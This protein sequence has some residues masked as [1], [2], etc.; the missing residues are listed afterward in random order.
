MKFLAQL[1]RAVAE[2][3]SAAIVTV[4]RAEGSTPR[5]QGAWMIVRPSGGFHGT[6]GGGALEWSLLHEAIARLSAGERGAQDFSRV[7]GPDLGQCCGGRVRGRIAFV[8][9]ED[10]GKLR[11]DPSKDMN[12]LASLTFDIEEEPPVTLY[13]F[14]AGHVGKALTLALAPLPFTIRWIDPRADIFPQ[15]TP[16]NV[17]PVVALSPADELAN[18]PDG[19]FILIMTHSHALDLEIT[20][21]AL[22]QDRFAFVG[23]IGSGSKRARFTSQMAARGIDE[24]AIA[25]LVCPIGVPGLPGKAPPIIA[26]SVAAQLLIEKARASAIA[27]DQRAIKWDR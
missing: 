15:A 17:T 10:I 27:L 14:G 13:L 19:A 3:G 4:T 18:A 7:L 9:R 21:S 8:T 12:V 22:R 20:I 16:A 6:I 2:E 1:S 26:A 23:L 11:Q 5:D 24:A 25:R